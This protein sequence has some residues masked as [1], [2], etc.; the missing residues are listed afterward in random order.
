MRHQNPSVGNLLAFRLKSAQM[1]NGEAPDMTQMPD[2]ADVEEGEERAA[3]KHDQGG[4]HRYR[5]RYRMRRH[6]SI[7]QRQPALMLLV[8]SLP[9]AFILVWLSA[10]KDGPHG[11]QEAPSVGT[12]PTVVRG[13]QSGA[14]VR[15]RI[16]EI[17]APPLVQ[18][19]LPDGFGPARSP[20][21]YLVVWLPILLVLE[22]VRRELFG[23]G[24]HYPGDP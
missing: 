15:P 19:D 8:V 9:S 14:G 18:Q 1:S 17:F 13:A 20:L 2:S 10:Y 21:P 16:A 5:R 12:S 22:F 7:W 24:P 4:R 6:R 3:E 23:R 11:L